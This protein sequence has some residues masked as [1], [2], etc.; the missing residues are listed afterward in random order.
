VGLARIFVLLVHRG[1][2]RGCLADELVQLV[3]ASARGLQPERR[4]GVAEPRVVVTKRGNHREV[5]WGGHAE[6]GQEAA[7]GVRALNAAAI[8]AIEAR[9]LLDELV[10]KAALKDVRLL[11]SSAAFCH[12]HGAAFAVPRCHAL[13]R[14]GARDRAQGRS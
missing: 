6:R 2:D 5:A 10:E 13:R 12:R 11:R 1:D 14:H 3:F 4:H 9:Q 8:C 7:R